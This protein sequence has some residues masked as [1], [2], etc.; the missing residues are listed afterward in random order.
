MIGL[1]SAKRLQTKSKSKTYSTS[2]SYIKKDFKYKYENYWQRRN[3]VLVGVRG[4]ASC[5]YHYELP[6]RYNWYYY[7]A[8]FVF[9]YNGARSLVTERSEKNRIALTVLWGGNTL[10]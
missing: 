8:A 3:R 2:Y 4:N 9:K 6:K 1:E 10:F 5:V 7:I